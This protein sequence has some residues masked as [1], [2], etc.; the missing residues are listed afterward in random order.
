M[1]KRFNIR[2]AFEEA[3]E[4]RETAQ[5]EVD[6]E[7]AM[8]P[9]EKAAR[10]SALQL[11][12]P[13][14]T[15]APVPIDGEV[16]PVETI[17]DDV[18]AVKEV[19]AVDTDGNI[20]SALPVAADTGV[21]AI[22]ADLVEAIKEEVKEE[23]KEPVAVEETT[24]DPDSEEAKQKESEAEERK[25]QEED[26]VKVLA[27]LESISGILNR[28]LDKGGLTPMSAS[29][30]TMALEQLYRRVGMSY[31]PASFPSMESY[32]SI[33]SRKRNTEVALES[34]NKSIKVVRS[35]L[36]RSVAKSA[37]PAKAAV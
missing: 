4:I 29:A 7:A 11:A 25:E 6:K 3:K 26:A 35:A 20:A 8:T 15:E 24:I 14:A 34:L 33:S 12:E 1:N 18:D 23:A 30:A 9:E 22:V 10:D 36:E 13:T 37:A 28:S 32:N 16:P 2:T 31:N 17:V 5:L 21:A 27:S 19:P